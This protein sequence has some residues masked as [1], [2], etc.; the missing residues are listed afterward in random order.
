MTILV[1]NTWF[2]CDLFVCIVFFSFLLYFCINI[3]QFV[4]RPVLLGPSAGCQKGPPGLC[5]Q[6]AVVILTSI[7]LSNLNY[8]FAV[9]WANKNMLAYY[10]IFQCFYK[11][12]QKLEIKSNL[13]PVKSNH[14]QYQHN[15]YSRVRNIVML[16]QIVICIC[17][18]LV[19]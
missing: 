19:V 1:R 17:P 18:S 6:P 9:F 5:W 16:N 15:K 7:L 10:E 13:R 8:I 11:D 3:W 14:C 2:A 4:R 12:Q